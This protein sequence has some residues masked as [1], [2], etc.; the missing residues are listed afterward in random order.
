MWSTVSPAV[1]GVLLLATQVSAKEEWLHDEWTKS[2]VLLE[3]GLENGTVGP[4]GNGF[5]VSYQD[6]DFL[7]TNRHLAERRGVVV[8]VGLSSRPGTP[9]RYSL[10]QVMRSTGLTWLLA[11]DADLAVVPLLLP[12]EAMQFADSLELSP[13]EVGSFK[14]WDFVRQ[15]DDVYIVGFPVFLGAG[16]YARPIL[17]SGTVA[18]KEREGEFLVDATGLPGSS[19][20]PVFLKLYRPDE[21]TGKLATGRA[22]FLVGIAGTHISYAEQAISTQTGRA[23]IVSEENSG[24]IVAYSAD[25]IAALLRNYVETY[26]VDSATRHK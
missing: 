24:L 21:R 19:G 13:L 25:R 10:D 26:D 5:V 22:S 23:K 9:L 15:G 20:G 6:K 12:T 16:S 4:L 11:P 17:R 2:V 3:Q 18:L 14:N 1:L 7:V 8:T